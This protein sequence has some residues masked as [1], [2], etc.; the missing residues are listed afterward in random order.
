MNKIKCVVCGGNTV[1]V[2]RMDRLPITGIYT[3]SSIAVEQSYDLCLL[4]CTRCTHMQLADHIPVEY[5]YNDTYKHRTSHSGFARRGVAKLIEALDLYNK[6]YDTNIYGNVVVDIGC[7]DGYLLSQLGDRTDRKVGIDPVA[8]NNDMDSMHY[9]VELI[10]GFIEDVDIAGI[11]PDMVVMRHTL[12]HIDAPYDTI[13]HISD[14]MRVGT[15]MVIQVPCSELMIED[16]RFDHIFHQ[17][18][19]YFSPKSLGKL[20]T[21]AGLL[22]IYVWWDRYDWGSIIMLSRKTSDSA[23]HK[24]DTLNICDT[25]YPDQIARLYDDYHDMMG[26]ID[27]IILNTKDNV[28]G[29]GAAQMLPVIAY[30][31][32]RGFERITEVVDDDP[33]KDGMYYSNLPIRIT[34]K[35]PDVM[36]NTFVITGVDSTRTIYRKLIDMEADRIISLLPV[37]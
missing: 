33:S 13:K 23:V 28:V 21:S 27:S 4:Q 15:Y 12:E 35:V 20:L 1:N 26:Q 14:S 24:A 22:P 10:K 11:D 25:L 31:M 19:N 18:L 7:S 9:D 34:N 3:A 6:E 29:Y 36:S 2:L 8:D 37:S 16:M 30:H 5:I 17:H 32:W